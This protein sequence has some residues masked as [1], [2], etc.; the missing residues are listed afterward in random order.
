MTDSPTPTPSAE[1]QAAGEDPAAT[2]EQGWQVTF[3]ND[4]IVVTNDEVVTEFGRLAD[5]IVQFATLDKNNQNAF[6]NNRTPIIGWLADEWAGATPPDPGM[7]DDVINTANEA[8]SAVGSDVPTA[9][10][11]LNRANTQLSQCED[12]W[13]E[14]LKDTT[15]GAIE[16]EKSALDVSIAVVAVA[17]TA[18]TGGTGALAAGAMGASQGALT[19]AVNQWVDMSQ[20]DQTQFDWS[21]FSVSAVTGLVAGALAG[22][23]SSALEEKIASACSNWFL[24][25]GSAELMEAVNEARQAAGM[26]SIEATE[27]MSWLQANIT[28]VLGSIPQQTVSSVTSALVTAG[29]TGDEF[30]EKLPDSLWDA[31]KDV[32]IDFVKENIG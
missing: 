7:W 30:T 27:G 31:G 21:A 28:R 1:S 15:K 6:M 18:A 23:A 26:S 20:G 11:S 24:G 9:A 4:Q 29:L 8:K 12:T 5:A 32:I 16:F 14:Y 22:A 25:A 2:T 3:G 10:E 19:N 13:K 17:V